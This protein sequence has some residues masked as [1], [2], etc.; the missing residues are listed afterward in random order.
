MRRTGEIQRKTPLQAKTPLKRTTAMNAAPLARSAVHA[1]S[2]KARN[3][4]KRTTAKGS[5]VPAKVRRALALRSEGL[6]E[7]MQPGCTGKATD[8]SHR[9]R[10]GMGG[11][12]GD[13]AV[14]HHV[15]SNAL[16][17]CRTC[18]SLRLHGQPTEA[19][20][21][22]WMLRDGSDPLAERVLYRGAWRFLDDLG[23][24]L[25]TPTSTAE[26]AS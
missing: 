12:H 4:P 20:A 3:A 26:E 17:A 23:A 5:Q 14:A 18:H 16:A 13:A 10:T 22:G 11:R 9:I 6:C 7:V 24:V 25:I 21:C 8:F 2:A 1:R 15:L 19:Y